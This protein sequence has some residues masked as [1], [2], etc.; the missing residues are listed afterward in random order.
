MSP[1]M[2]P[3]G[4]IDMTAPDDAR[5]ASRVAVDDVTRGIR[6]GYDA[7]LPWYLRE[8][9][10]WAY[11]NPINARLLDHESV[12]RIILFNNS[13]RLRRAVLN[14]IAP[15]QRVLQAAHV[16]GRLIP[17]MA[18]KVGSAGHLEVIDIA[19]LQVELCRRKV[20]GLTQVRVR[21]A[22]AERPGRR[23]YDIVSCFFLLHELP[24]RHRRLV[25]E[26]LLGAVAPGGKAVFVDYHGPVRGNPLRWPMSRLFARFEPFAEDLWT[27]PIAGLAGCRDEFRWHTR[28]YFGGLYQL[29]TATRPTGARSG[30][31]RDCEMRP[32][33]AASASPR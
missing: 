26:A 30:R 29:T 6:G 20:E 13:G 32:T 28:T 16:Y 14:E 9:Y 24:D 10:G 4:E 25:V 12:V 22:N 11:L 33:R 23:R 15:G 31:E 18:D 19:P 1:A 7:T 8:V 27:T 17:E 3:A 21:Q 2:P 5:S